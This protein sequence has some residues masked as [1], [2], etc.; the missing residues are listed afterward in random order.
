MIWPKTGRVCEAQRNTPL[1]V[2]CGRREWKVD[3]WRGLTSYS[4]TFYF[5]PS[6]LYFSAKGGKIVGCVKRS[7][8]HHARPRGVQR[9]DTYL[10]RKQQGTAVTNALLRPPFWCVPRCCTHPTPLPILFFPNSLNSSNS[11]CNFPRMGESQHRDT[12]ILPSFPPDALREPLQTREGCQS[13]W[14]N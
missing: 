7:G 2:V 13:C 5:H 10:P 4:S 6:Q 3:R 8:T 1:R 9:P 12:S 11:V 14:A